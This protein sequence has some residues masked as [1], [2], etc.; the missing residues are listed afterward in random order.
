MLQHYLKVAL[1]H[2]GR[3]KGYAFINVAGLAVGIAC[4]VLIG[5]FVRHETSFDRFHEH[6]DRI[7]RVVQE[8]RFGTVQQVAV[9]SGP[10]APALEAGLPEVEHAVR[11]LSRSGGL[12][13]DGEPT[14]EADVYFTDPP[15]FDVF[16]FPLLRGDPD[17]ALAEPNTVVLTEELAASVFGTEDPIGQV[18][19]LEDEDLRVTGVMADVSPTSHFRFDALASYATRQEQWLQEW[20]AN[21]LWTFVLLQ[22]GATQAATD[23]RLQSLAAAHRG[24]EGIEGVTYYLQPL[25]DI[26]FRTGMVAENA[27]VG[28]VAVVYVFSAIA[29]FILFIASI[30]YVNL[31]TA[32]SMQRMREIGVR[33]ALGAVRTQL[34]RQF[35]GESLLMAGLALAV[36]VGLAS[37]SLPLLNRLLE[38]ELSFSSVPLPMGFGALAAVFAL[39]GLLAGAY[40]ALHLS[41]FRPVA[42]LKGTLPALSGGAGFR[43]GLVVFQ[44]TVSVVLL[45]AVGVAYQ[46]LRF[47][48]RTHLGFDEE[49][50]VSFEVGDAAETE[51]LRREVAALPQVVR[52]AAA[53][54]PLGGFF[55][56]TTMYAEGASDDESL[57]LSYVHVDPDFAAT[58]G[59]ELAAG[60]GFAWGRS[61]DS[62]GAVV[63]NETAVRAFGWASAGAAVGRRILDGEDAYEV[64]GVVR[65]FHFASLHQPIEPLM[66]FWHPTAMST[67]T[68]RL[69]RDDVPGALAALEAAWTH[70]LPDRPFDYAFVDERLDELYKGDRKLG[71]LFGVFALLAIGIA[72]LGLFGLAAFTAER[73]T[74]EIG[75]RKVLGASVASLAGLLSMDFLKLVLVASVL[76]VPVAYLAMRR[77]LEGFAYHVE[78]SPAVFVGAGAVALLIAL[79]TVITQ[80][81]RAASAD[82]VTALRNE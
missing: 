47:V 7:Y 48:Q 67:V 29:L 43:K 18:V 39:M 64:V 25:T 61:S 72:C 65:D 77:W 63:L 44:F 76:A 38:L 75:V 34:V 71:G 59:I 6:A 73:R 41:R 14:V 81:L 55:S 50:L 33:K 52:S 82:P 27:T 79:L 10:M 24:E 49:H 8:Q 37:L 4:C 42:V 51:R 9:V 40:P 54:R 70:V 5:L 21:T 53:E 36:G 16:S 12:Y 58:A 35:L 26:H 13:V 80:A 19:R 69:R 32:R 78:I 74:K 45:A 17:R 11:F 62:T 68:A 3:Q 46:Q 30:N 15:V 31:A 22:E 1:R 23:A 66:L 28:D 20:G 2:L 56:Q 60:R 57:M